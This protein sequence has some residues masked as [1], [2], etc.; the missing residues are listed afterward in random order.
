MTPLGRTLFFSADDGAIGN[1]LWKFD[2]IDDEAG[3]VKDIHPGSASSIPAWLTNVN[4]TLCF[5]AY[6][7]VHGQELWQSD[8]TPSGTVLV[9]DIR[10]GGID[11]EIQYAAKVNGAYYFAAN[12]G[13]GREPWVYVPPA[14]VA[15]R[16]AFYNNSFFDGNDAAAGASDDGAIDTTKS[17]LLPGGTAGFANYTSYSKGINGLLIDIASPGGAISAGDFAFKVGNDSNPAGWPALTVQPSVSVRSGAGIGG[18]DR[19]T[20]IW[21]DGAIK[22]TWLEV[23]VLANANTG[24]AAADVFY[25]GNA[26]GE[27]GNST[28]NAQVNSADEGLIRLNGRNALN[29]A[30]V[31]FSYDINRDRVVNSTDQVIARL[32]ATSALT[33]LRL[34]APAGG[35]TASQ[36]ATGVASYSALV[37]AAIAEN[38]L[39]QSLPRRR[40]R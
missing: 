20:L 40:R 37:D 22:N 27:T 38:S 35:A 34:I 11:A 14:R 15:N 32:N 19:V 17:A 1:E 21:P 24:L 8:G 25:F 12:N 9:M 39:A 10:P 29:P 31:D 26:V 5:S 16:Q 13:V 3:L 23:S 28:A 30:P 18:S 7:D 36:A 2:T 6:D 33:A 4:G